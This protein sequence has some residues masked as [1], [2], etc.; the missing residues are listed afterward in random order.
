[1]IEAESV[2]RSANAETRNPSFVLLI[3]QTLNLFKNIRLMEKKIKRRNAIARST[4]KAVCFVISFLL[5]WE[6]PTRLPKMRHSESKIP[7]KLIN[8]KLGR[9][10]MSIV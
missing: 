1:M 5:V 3:D 7:R 9:K 6:T 10:I 2:S 8:E 4:T